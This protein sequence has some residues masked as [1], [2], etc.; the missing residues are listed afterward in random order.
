MA[1]FSVEY[2][3]KH[4]SRLALLMLCTFAIAMQAQAYRI[5]ENSGT[6][7]TPASY[8]TGTTASNTKN[9]AGFTNLTATLSINSGTYTISNFGCG[10]FGL[11]AC[12]AP[13]L[14]LSN[15]DV[16]GARETNVTNN[17]TSSMF[18][19]ALPINNTRTASASNMPAWRVVHSVGGCP[20][21]SSNECTTGN[22]TITLS[23]NRPVLNPVIHLSELGGLLGT[24]GNPTATV[25]TRLTINQVNGGSASAATLE[26][27]SSNSNLQVVS[28]NKIQTTNNAA[29]STISCTSGGT[30][31]GCGSIRVKGTI[32]SIRFSSAIYINRM[33]GDATADTGDGYAIAVTVDEDFGDAPASYDNDTTNGAASHVVGELYLG[34]GIGIDKT[35]VLNYS[36]APLT[37]N[38][39]TVGDTNDN[40]V[41]FNPINGLSIGATTTAAVSVSA[42]TQTANVCGWIDFNVNGVFDN[43]NE[44]ACTSSPAGAV[45][46]VTLTWTIPTGASVTAGTRQGRVRVSYDTTNVQNPTGRLDSGEVEDHLV[47][48][49]ALTG[50]TPLSCGSNMY[51]LLGDTTNGFKS[52]R[53][54]ST[55]GTPSGTTYTVT[56][57]PNSAPTNTN[58]ALAVS[59]DGTKIF[60]PT[61]YET[62]W[63]YD[64]NGGGAGTG[65]VVSNNAFA[66]R[67]S[68][69]RMLRATV[70]NNNIGYFGATNQLYRFSTTSPFTVSAPVTMTVINPASFGSLSPAPSVSGSGDFFADSNG[71]LFLSVNPTGQTFIDTFRI[72]ANGNTIFLGRITQGV[73]SDTYGGYAALPTGVYASSSAGRIVSVDF[74]DFIAS[75]TATASSAAGNSDL[76]SCYYPLLSPNVVVQ[77]TATKVAGSSGTIVRSGDTLEYNIVVRNTGTLATAGATFQDSIP[78]GTTYVAGSTFYNYNTST[79]AATALADDA[80][81][82]M[83]FVTERHIESPGQGDGT[84]LVDK[85]TGSTTADRD[86]EVLI[87]F[88]VTVNA[89]AVSVQNQGIAKY[90]D[91]P[92]PPTYTSIVSDDPGT[93]ATNDSTNIS[94]E[95]ADLVITKDDAVTSVVAG[96]ATTYTITVTNNGPFDVTNP[97]IADPQVVGIVQKTVTCAVPASGTAVCPT[98]AN[99][100]LANFKAGIAIPAIPVGQSVIFTL[101]A[102][103]S[104]TS[105]TV[106]NVA[107]ITSTITDPDTSN[108]TATD[109]NTVTAPTAITA[110]TPQKEARFTAVPDLPT[111][112]RGA[113]GSQIITITNN[114]PDSATN[115]IA[116][117][118]PVTQTGVSVTAVSVVG[119]GVCTFAAG[120]WTCPTIPTVANAG[121]FQLNVTYATTSAAALGQ[122]PQA[123]IRVKSD[124]FNPGSGVNETLYKVWGSNQ[125]NEIRPNGAFWVGYEGTGGTTAVGTAYDEANPILNAWPA[126]QASPTGAY[127]VT[128]NPSRRTSVYA[129]SST[130]AAPTISRIVTNMSTDVNKSVVLPLLSNEYA[131]DNR[132]AW[133]YRTG[134]YVP[135]AQSLSFCIANT[136]VGIDD[137][138]YIMVDGVVQATQDTYV[139][140]GIVSA[141]VS[142]GAGY[143]ALVYRISNQNTAANSAEVGAGGYGSIGV[144]TSGTCNTSGFDQ[145]GNTA[146]PASVNIIDAA[147]LSVTKTNSVSAVNAGGTTS[148]SIVVSN[149]GPSMADAAVFQDAAATGLT[150]TSVSCVAAGGAVCPTTPTVAQIEAGLAIPTLPSGGSVTFTVGANVTATSGSV[151]NIATV[152]APAGTTEIN[153]ANNSATD[154]DGVLSADLVITKSGPSTAKAGDY[155]TYTLKVWNKGPTAVTDA[156]VTDI[157]PSQLSGVY[158]RCTATG[159]AT[160]GSFAASTSG[161]NT[162]SATTLNLPADATGN[163]HYVTYQITALA[164]STGALTNT[165]TV[166]SATMPE[167][168]NAD[169]SA[170]QATTITVDAP[171]TT[172]NAADQC[173]AADARNVLTP[174]SFTSYSANHATQTLTA[175]INNANTAKGTGTNGAL[176]LTGKASWSYGNPHITA[177]T[178]TLNVNGTAYAVLT[179]VGASSNPNQ[180]T[181]T[182]LNGATISPATVTLGSYNQV[183]TAVDFT[184]TLPTT[185]TTVNTATAVF[186][187]IS[188]TGSASVAGDDVGVQLNGVLQ[189][190]PKT[191]LSI[192]KTNSVSVLNAGGSTSYSVVVT[193]TGSSAADGA[194]FQDAAVA[195]LSKTSVSCVSAG[196]AVCPTT[197]TVAQIE[198]GLAIP[199]LPSGG[200]ATFTVGAN[201]TAASG[202]VSN[203]ATVSVPSGTLDTNSA[204]NSATD[205]DT[206][207][208]RADLSITKTNGVTNVNAGAS[209]SY[210]IVVSNAGPSAANAAVFQDAAATGLTKTSVS[211]VAAGSAVCPTS[212]TV[213]QIEAGLAIPTLP[214]GGSVTFTVGATVTATSGTF[215]NTATIT[216]PSGTTEINTANNS[217]TDTDS[218]IETSVSIAGRVFT[219]NSGTTGNAS[220]AYNSVQDAGEVGLAA[221]TVQLTNCSNTILASTKTDALGDY[222]F[223]VLQNS[224]SAPNFCVVEQNGVGYTSVSGT[225]GY[226]RSADSITLAKTAATSYSGHNFGDARLGLMLTS[227]GQQTTTPAGTVS[228]AHTLTT[229]AVLTPTFATTTSQQP[230]N[231]ADQS[232]TTLLYL[233]NNCNG[234]VDGSEAP[235]GT[236]PTLLPNQSVCVVQ[237][238]NAPASASNGAQHVAS[239][240]A[241]YVATVQGGATLNGNSQTRT[242]TTLVGTAGLDMTKQVRVVSSCPS[243]DSSSTGFVA[244]NTAKNGDFL[245]YEI[246]YTNRSARNL[247]EVVVRDAV[248]STALFKSALCM[249]TPSG[250]ACA[251]GSTPAVNANGTLRWN[252]TGPV[253]PNAQGRVR[254]CVQ[255][256][257]LA[258]GPQ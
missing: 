180:A 12:T 115:A 221:V 15:N 153:S 111:I 121:T 206:V 56:D 109:S 189:C 25:H 218:V 88:R 98:V 57:D 148:Y 92:G 39:G 251:V 149:A 234:Q 99:L 240:S 209:T 27:L 250:A 229:E 199:T 139:G 91:D 3:L 79:K 198:A 136:S 22:N 168:N 34:G 117:F 93:P 14:Q 114:G 219:D 31:T 241:S 120:E 58:A 77:K 190:L 13:Y 26:L 44:R 216:A 231:A 177:A 124:E 160:C 248:P 6:V 72:A 81:G 173:L 170:S 69:V 37:T 118:K 126:T 51:A 223:N 258:E 102:D 208:P 104:A 40:G 123:E 150:K 142:L 96:G 82:V 228:Y 238:V 48:V 130:S 86:K 43:T 233:D 108:N 256:P 128:A 211:C 1:F 145:W 50:G 235:V 193:N 147:D 212:P 181:W 210:S 95:N 97:V 174:T 106:S 68:S 21:T 23:F 100:T 179:T 107:T 225:S 186:Q 244:R 166:S 178:L 161:S 8:S 47:T 80:G 7:S 236:L 196:G 2:T 217:A 247:S 239:L 52:I 191:D 64:V 5:G 29:G 246:I 224:L 185:V 237:R 143:H 162:R 113:G 183:N 75:E 17:A 61:D 10:T 132:R 110:D 74:D 187:N 18:T 201:V 214:S 131:G 202:S 158:M 73:T 105:G 125:T 192:S 232:W 207:T 140:G 49:N 38:N 127:L 32:S 222:T 226:S 163:T 66:T 16:L 42:H 55:T 151:A 203:T 257:A 60:V 220:N 101:T 249:S 84:L 45:S 70:T 119:G 30:N 245:E 46:A 63:V 152:T 215:A 135:T 243:N 253:A 4:T 54:L 154:T 194:V 176:V 242:D 83:P 227:D 20:K 165:A 112:Y 197:P 9:I 230:N 252:I 28:P 254:F 156:V 144:S 90:I 182:A 122:A 138:A 71:S 167:L 195:G 89:G 200:S 141:S 41:T 164:Y 205:T 36:N 175:V 19:P 159:S 85:T 35:D 171:V 204:N 78:A 94:V 133:E 155:L 137:G 146:V 116:T 11:S 184:L 213:A 134:I 172:G 169:N 255:V 65:A 129:A 59:S 33:T 62:L 103:I 53:R 157:V 87:T 188:P 76:A 67:S 24:E